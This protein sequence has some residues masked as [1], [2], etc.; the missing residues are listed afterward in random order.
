MR[1]AAKAWRD[2]AKASQSSAESLAKIAETLSR[3]LKGQE[4]L[5]APA[6][7]SDAPP[8]VAE[9]SAEKEKAE[10]AP[11]LSYGLGLSL[12]AVTGNANA[13]S[14]KVAA[15][16]TGILGVW[17]FKASSF[18]AYGQTTAKSVADSQVTALNANLDLRGD[19]ELSKVFSSYVQVGASTDHVASIEWQG[20]AELGASITWWEE[21]EGTTKVS[22]EGVKE[23]TTY[24][25]SRFSSDLGVRYTRESRFQYYPVAKNGDDLDIFSPRLGLSLRYALSRRASF[26]EEAE[27]LPDVV[28]TKNLR[29]ISNSVL[30]AQIVD[31]IT[32]NISFKIRT[33]GSPAENKKPTDTELSAGVAWTF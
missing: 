1:E 11:P 28:D 29:A 4:A 26:V 27:I 30:S 32:L 20:R 19:R 5:A 12:I 15:S 33:I 24:I 17:K 13:V 2:A 31:G 7:S 8:Q 10:E 25:K 16:V 22:K 18:A 14:A 3:Q 6:P 9:G 23:D 21:I